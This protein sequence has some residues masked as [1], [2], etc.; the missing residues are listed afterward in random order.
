MIDGQRL[1]PARLPDEPFEGAHR[2]HRHSDP[3]DLSD[4]A[5]CALQALREDDYHPAGT[6]RMGPPGTRAV[7]IRGAG[8]GLEACALRPLGDA[9]INARNTN[10]RP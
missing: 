8:A 7:P 5:S 10:A 4:E 9:D 1:L 2:V 3:A 6:C